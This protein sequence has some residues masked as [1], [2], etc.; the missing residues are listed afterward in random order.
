MHCLLFYL[1]IYLFIYWTHL[2]L[3]GNLSWGLTSPA[4]ATR[5]A[6]MT[7]IK[8]HVGLSL[9]QGHI[10]HTVFQVP[11]RTLFPQSHICF[12]WV[13]VSFV[14]FLVPTL[15]SFLDYCA[16]TPV[17]GGGL[18]P[19]NHTQSRTHWVNADFSDAQSDTRFEPGTLGSPVRCLDHYTTPAVTQIEKKIFFMYD[20]IY[21]FWNTIYNVLDFSECTLLI[22]VR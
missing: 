14:I 6:L 7:G 18:S 9:S 19:P 2:S 3:A 13:F 10:L 15:S 21:F 1:F 22:V 16:T 8:W 11:Y 5:A 17:L 12:L 20:L 4:A